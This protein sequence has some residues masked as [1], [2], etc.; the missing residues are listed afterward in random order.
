MRGRYLIAAAATAMLVWAGAALAIVSRGG[1][2]KAD[3]PVPRVVGLRGDDAAVNLEAAGLRFYADEHL[4]AFESS[5]KDWSMTTT[6]S[7]R[8]VVVAQSPNAGA[9]V[10]PGSTVELSVQHRP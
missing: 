10:R 9:S 3:V 7:L 6:Q 2:R 5:P 8:G 1:T 4:R